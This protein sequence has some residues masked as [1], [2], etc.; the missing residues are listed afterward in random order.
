MLV[1]KSVDEFR[2]DLNKLCKWSQEWQM[3]F[4][5]NKCSVMESRNR[6]VE[7]EFGGQVLNQSE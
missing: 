1:R 2:T 6:M 4:N 3:L 5:V 7:C